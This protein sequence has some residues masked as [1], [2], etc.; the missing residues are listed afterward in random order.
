MKKSKMRSDHYTTIS[1][2]EYIELQNLIALLHAR[3]QKARGYLELGKADDALALLKQ[4]N[5]LG[6][7]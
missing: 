3:I 1:I 6:E 5:D 7:K 4:E 2:E